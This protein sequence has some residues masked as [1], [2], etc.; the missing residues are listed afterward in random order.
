M[1]GDP[2]NESAVRRLVEQHGLDWIYREQTG[3]TNTDVLDYHTNHG[4]EVVA[5]SET[6]SSGR[7]RRGREWL[8]P[9]ACN[10]YC[11]VGIAKK[12]HA[13]QQGL[14]SIVTG[15]ALCRALR[16]VADAEVKL[17]W[18]NDVLCDGRKLGG[19]LIES[20]PLDAQRLYFAIGFGINIF[21]NSD[22]LAAIP[23]AVTS[24]DRVTSTRLDRSE[25]LIAVIESV[26]E[27]IRVFDQAEVAELTS[28]FAQ[29]DAF[30]GRRIEVVSAQNRI[31]GINR[32]V[33]PD[34]QLRLETE[35]GIETHSAAEISLRGIT[36]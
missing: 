33:A 13:S 1:R 18:P 30:H 9:F 31:T 29:L 2:I 3:S 28:E 19:I 32:G 4:R 26:I 21:M 5:V 15:V 14:L 16:H 17:K 8:S 22:E 35:H 24:L 12:I 34:G 23:Q 27:S 25:V 36:E 20:R 11:T 10:I 6:Q 7:G